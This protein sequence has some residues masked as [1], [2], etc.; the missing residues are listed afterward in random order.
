MRYKIQ[1]VFT[2][3]GRTGLNNLLSLIA[4]AFFTVLLNTFLFIHSSVYKELDLKETVPSLIAF[5]NDT[6]VEEDAQV[7]AN[8]IQ[9]KDHILY[10][11]YISKEENFNR[12]E[13]QFGS[14][15]GLIKNGVSDSNPFPASLEIYVNPIDGSR[16]KLEEIAFDIESYDEIDDVIFTRQG[17]LTDLFRQTN[18]TTIASIAIAI[19]ITLFIIR[20]AVLKTAQSRHEEIQLLDLIGATRVHLRIPFFIHGIFLGLSG[21]ILGLTCFYLLY[22]LLTFQLGVLEFLPYYQLISIVVAGIIIGL[23]AGIFAQRKY[24]KSYRTNL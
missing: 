19:L 24:F 7:F 14:L 10:I 12:A 8:Q 6:V 9:K 1:N 23:F 5:A 20:A 4:L 15:G 18:R 13:K 17:I 21:T 16:K 2:H 22:C 11:D 3:I